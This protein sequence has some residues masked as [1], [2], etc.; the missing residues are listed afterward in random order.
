MKENRLLYILI[1]YKTTDQQKIGRHKL[2]WKDSFPPRWN[3]LKG[4]ILEAD[5]DELAEMGHSEYI[6]STG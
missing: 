5:N 2:R 3:R 4:L 6:H 1:L